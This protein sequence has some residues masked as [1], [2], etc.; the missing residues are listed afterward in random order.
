MT[1]IATSL[2]TYTAPKQSSDMA[3][4]TASRSHQELRVYITAI[5]MPYKMATSIQ[6]LYTSSV[7]YGA[8]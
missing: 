7:V 5:L 1:C 2:T 3:V 6:K 8:T 4:S